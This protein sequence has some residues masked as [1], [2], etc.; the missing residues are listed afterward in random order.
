M[1]NKNIVVITGQVLPIVTELLAPHC[2]IKHWD[3]KAPMPRN[4]LY[5]WLV[6]ATGLFATDRVTIDEDLLAHAPQ[7]R[8]IAQASVGYDN[9]DIDA[10]TARGIPFSNTP[11]VLINTTADLAFGLL[12]TAAR[13][14]HE[15]WNFVRSG[16]WQHGARLPFGVDLHGKTLGIVGMGQIGAAVAKR[17]QASGM[18]VIYHNRKK[19]SDDQELGAT[20]TPFDTLLATADFIVVLV[21]LSAQ[22]RGMFGREQFAKMKA[23]AYFINAA[24]G[25]LVDTTALYEA[26]RDHRIAYAALDVTDP[27]P[28]PAEHSLLNLSNILITPH[29]GSAT[30]ETRTRMA[31]LAV[32]NLLAGLTKKPLPTCVNKTVNY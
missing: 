8:V 5:E 4:L 27:E 28:L 23:S 17:A 20:Y 9:V 29:I 3:Q 31:T 6:N 14:I 30:S 15:G 22:S 12:L 18:H 26:L 19:R 25:G 21:P 13:R 24:R 32:Q 10:C 1:I 2:V 7:L 11:G 16:Q